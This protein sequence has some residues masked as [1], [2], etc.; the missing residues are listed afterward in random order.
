MHVHA[1]VVEI[2]RTGNDVVNA[3]NVVAVRW[4][5]LSQC[6]LIVLV[7]NGHTTI[8]CGKQQH[9]KWTIEYDAS[10]TTPNDKWHGSTALIKFKPSL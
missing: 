1:G 5:L 3:M 4:Q 7:G 2:P 9:N 10:Y 8:Q 6:T